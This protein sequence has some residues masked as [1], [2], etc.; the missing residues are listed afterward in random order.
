MLT[1]V[2][3]LQEESGCECKR[4]NTAVEQ[5]LLAINQEIMDMKIKQNAFEWD[6]NDLLM[7]QNKP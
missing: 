5:Q 6:L 7:N 1:Y 4:M 2:F 3:I